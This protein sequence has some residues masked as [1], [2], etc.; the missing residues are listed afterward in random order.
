MPRQIALLATVLALL[1]ATPWLSPGPAALAA[2]AALP[3]GPATAPEPRA[4]AAPAF[5]GPSA[6]SYVDGLA[7][8]IGSRPVGSENNQRAQQYL[9]DQYRQLGY[10]ADLQ[11]FTV[12]SYDDRGST[13]TLGGKSFVVTTLQYSTAG[14]VAGELVDAGLGRPEDYEDAGVVGKVVLVSRGDIRF[15]D[16]LD[17]AVAA[18]ARA[19]IIYNNQPGNFTGSL[20][21]VSKIPAVS[22]A[23]ADGQELRQAIRAGNTNVHVTVDAS[24]AQST[25][26][27]VVAI[28]PGGPRSIVIG[29]HFDTVAAGP[30]ANDNG[31]GTATTLE[32]ARVMAQAQTPFTL[33][34]VAFDAEEIGLYGSAHYVAALSDA[35]R[36]SIV[37]MVNLDMVGV[38]TETRVGGTESLTT[39]ARAAASKVGIDA[40]SMGDAPGA[41]DHASFLRANI[42]SVFI[43]RSND[44]NYHS[45]NDVAQYVDPANLELAGK[46]VLDIVTSLERAE[47]ASHA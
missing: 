2:P 40:D 31:S 10:Q 41:S 17:A 11:P 4:D 24:M 39:L 18:G 8:N 46:I 43:Y 14:D 26:A 7:V 42:P 12:T 37:A 13:L 28:K 34:F 9:L 3:A 22:V 36:Q 30:G 35:E 15:V 44:P 16:K 29:G 6:R 27:N 25:A 32:I 19:V 33:R 1:L 45:P 38:G 5:N 47:Q 21:G 20:I 23:Q